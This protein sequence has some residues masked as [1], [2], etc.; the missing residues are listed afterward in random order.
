M[1]TTQKWNIMFLIGM[2][3]NAIV[4]M[5]CLS[6]SVYNQRP[7]ITYNSEQPQQ[8]QSMVIIDYFVY[9][10]RAGGMKGSF[11]GTQV[12]WKAGDKVF[13]PSGSHALV[14]NYIVGTE[15]ATRLGITYDFEPG[16]AY[17]VDVK[18]DGRYVR[19]VIEVLGVLPWKLP[20]VS[21]DPT[22]FEGT[23]KS[24]TDTIVFSGNTLITSKD[25]FEGMI[26]IRGSFRRY[27]K[28]VFTF[29]DQ[30]MALQSF[31]AGPSETTWES[32][33]FGSEPRNVKYEFKDDGGLV[34]TYGRRSATYYKKK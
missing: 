26:W 25:T 15:Y 3:L 19:P 30:I 10:K 29:T 18:K 33:G 34:L 1:K 31:E 24:T 2:A 4:L 6:T 20:P 8:E 21:K 14:Y 22:K 12:K 13:I 5:G 32:Y 16:C 28:S 9:F 27:T 11:D 23:W 7:P 17:Y